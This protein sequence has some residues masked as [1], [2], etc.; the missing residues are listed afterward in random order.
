MIRRL[1]ALLI[2]IIALSSTVVVAQ[3]QTITTYKGK[4]VVGN[5]ILVKI[6]PNSTAKLNG[7]TISALERAV[8]VKTVNRI[9]VQKTVANNSV[10]VWKSDLPVEK[11]LQLARSIPGV[12]ASPNY[13]YELPKVQKS[14]LSAN[15]IKELES[16]KIQYRSSDWFTKQVKPATLQRSVGNNFAELTNIQLKPNAGVKNRIP[17][18]NAVGELVWS[19]NFEDSASTASNWIISNSGDGD[20]W[21]YVKDSVEVEESPEAYEVNRYFAIGSMDG[22]YLPNTFSSVVS[23]VYDMTAL[24][25]D[26]G[27]ELSIDAVS[28]VE[29]GYDPFFLQ[30]YINDEVVYTYDL[31]SDTGEPQTI[32]MDI[33]N[34]AGQSNVYFAFTFISD[35][36]FEVGFG[37]AFDNLSISTTEK[38]ITNDPLLS[39]QYALNND[40][41]FNG[42]SVE[43]ADISAFDAWNYS[44]GSSEVLVVVY[45]SGSDLDHPDLVDNLWVNPNEIADN[46]VDDDGNGYVDD[47]YGWDAVYQNG[48]PN[49]G[50]GHGSHVAGIIGAKGNNGVGISGI[51]Q[52]VKIITVRIFDE[53][54]QTT[55]DAILAGYDYIS[56][57][58]AQGLPIVAVNQSWGGGIDYGEDA[59]VVAEAYRDMADLHG[60][61]NTIWVVS[62]GNSALDHDKLQ[63]QR[64]PDPIQAPNII[65]VASTDFMD[66][67]SDFSDYGF[68]TVEI[69]APGTAILSTIPDGYEFYSG[70][71]MASPYVTG[72]IALAA[73]VYADE[74]ASSRIARVMATADQISSLTDKTITG[75]RLNAHAAVSTG[76]MVTDDKL[77]SASPSRG[78]FNRSDVNVAFSAGFVNTSETEVTVNA[79]SVSGTDATD[80]YLHEG[81]LDQAVVVGSGAAF[82]VG[83]G[84]YRN[85]EKEMYDAT[86]IFETSD[87]NI[88]I[89]VMLMT[90]AEPILSVDNL[91][92]DRGQITFGE[93]ISATFTIGNEGN[94]DL[95]YEVLQGVFSMDEEAFK[96]SFKPEVSK[97]VKPK[98]SFAKVVADDFNTAQLALFGKNRKTIGLD[99]ETSTKV[100][101]GSLLNDESEFYY[102]EDFNDAQTVAESWEVLQMSEGN[103]WV[104]ADLS[105]TE[106]PDNVFL[107]GDFVDGY[108]PS[109]LTVAASPLFDFTDLAVSGDAPYYLTFDYAAQLEDEADFF[110]VN[111]LQDGYRIATVAL[112]GRNLMNDGNTYQAAFDISFLA[113]QKNVEFWF[114][115]NY[116]GDVTAGFGSMFDNVGIST[117][118]AAFFATNYGG[119]LGEGTTQEIGVTARTGLIGTGSFVLA[120][121][122]ISDA[123]NDIQGYGPGIIEHYVYFESTY[124][125][126]V[127]VEPQFVDAGN[128]GKSDEMLNGTFSM[129]NSGSLD[130]EFMTFSLLQP[131]F[132]EPLK[133]AA[134]MG[135]E[136][137]EAT[138]KLA[139]SVKPSTEAK[140]SPKRSIAEVNAAVKG[141]IRKPSTHR[142]SADGKTYVPRLNAKSNWL[143]HSGAPQIAENLYL[144]E[145]F[146]ASTELP[147]GWDILDISENGYTWNVLPLVEGDNVLYFGDPET[148][149]YGNDSFVLALSPYFNLSEVGD[150]KNVF[151]EFDYSA[152]LESG[153]DFLEVFIGTDEDPLAYYLGSSEDALWNN[154]EINMANFDIS[155]LAGMPNDFFLTFVV[156]SDFSF[157]EGFSLIDNIAVY[158]EE[159]IAYMSPRMGTFEAGSTIEIDYHVNLTMLPPMSYQL[160]NLV[161]YSNGTNVSDVAFQSTIFSI[162]NM[163]PVAVN[164]TL[165]VMAGDVIDIV[166]MMQAMLE[167][168]MDPDGDELYVEHATDPIYGEWKSITYNTPWWW[169]GPTHYVAPLNYDG[170]DRIEYLVS[171][172]FDY[173]TAVVWLMVMQEPEFVTGV[174]QQYSFLEDEVLTLNTIKMAAGVGGMNP[175]IRVW[176]ATAH[177]A[178]HM[179]MPEDAHQV[180]VFADENFFGQ[181]MARFYVGEDGEAYDSLDVTLV[182]VP[183]NDA[184]IAVFEADIEKNVISFTDLSSDALDPNGRIEKWFWDFGDSN[185]SEEVSPV[186]TYSAVGEY[187]VTLT[188]TDNEG[189]TASFESVVNVTDITSAE[190]EIM[191]TA[192]EL[193]QN[194]PNPFNPSTT[195]KFAV[196]ATNKVTI[197]VFNIV[198]QKVASIAQAQ[199][200]NAGI[201]QVTFDASHLASGTYL[202]RIQAIDANGLVQTSTR[203][204]VLIK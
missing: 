155:S 34:V 152:Y 139:S 15:V 60:S 14:A 17:S 69:G 191:P 81:A 104:L 198:G 53:N 18:V 22:T 29:L 2:A 19:E 190:T 35:D 77:V 59:V 193:S 129:T 86:L 94:G 148:F 156:S 74:S 101:F 199:T 12:K 8:Q 113:G 47:V 70:T 38:A 169:D 98:R 31:S 54:G 171:D 157:D 52:D 173:D 121:A 65:S 16:Q 106:T 109:T 85:T 188:V 142:F 180:H 187:T 76:D 68:Y 165:A 4:K 28:V 80:F 75:A 177:E 144:Y 203:K 96:V 82:G 178:V 26:F 79:V 118:P 33:S 179:D 97:V 126:F 87:G 154:G 50:D 150:S 189:A 30:I 110:Y 175:N 88:E 41:T 186:H 174:Q 108:L 42:G 45:D 9:E 160:I 32:S 90:Q 24:S 13:V 182:I 27:Y 11:M 135:A 128:F 147:L 44:T 197:E 57:L 158:D 93:E 71:S 95:N 130:F 116:D 185:T 100:K 164:D 66:G 146:D 48:Y 168:D 184:P 127:T 46:G 162:T 161:G 51:N 72:V 49:D 202:Y 194:Y 166:T 134:F 123:V 114:I 92:E 21:T 107:A 140:A 20:V 136:K 159:S 119:T 141:K 99:A 84:A 56:A 172:G 145:N 64:Y 36:L 3:S 132:E 40:G 112:T 124:A 25:S 131:I 61:Y 10:E 78:L 196:P 117:G 6:D 137:M 63:Y 37:A 151:V 43:G 39:L 58:L 201:H 122:I 143:K 200:Y 133:K 204:M 91:E 163:A 149:L 67:L 125:P 167:N 138:Q 181:V 5:S 192:F 170:L 115:A 183:V 83:L 7:T 102:F 176:G 195:I 62:A 105:E 55:G 120:T 111:I 1:R 153:Y 23:P 73:S 103:E 89:P